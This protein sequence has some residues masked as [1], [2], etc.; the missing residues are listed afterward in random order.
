LEKQE[1]VYLSVGGIITANVT[2]LG[3]VRGKNAPIFD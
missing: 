1:T 2:V 3:A